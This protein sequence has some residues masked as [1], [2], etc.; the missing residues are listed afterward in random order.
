MDY[1]TKT[2]AG[3]VVQL[4]EHEL[5]AVEYAE[6]KA[7]QAFNIVDGRLEKIIAHKSHPARAGLIWQN[8]FYGKKRRKGVWHLTKLQL[9]NAPLFTY[10]E[11]VDEVCKYV[12]L[13]KEE[14][15]FYKDLAARSGISQLTNSPQTTSEQTCP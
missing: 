2:S 12:H 1:S 5:A 11:M 10:P 14:I 6:Q 15:A 7:P 3:N 8:A 9:G 13:S 4:L